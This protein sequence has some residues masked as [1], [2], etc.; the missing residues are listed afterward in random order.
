MFLSFFKIPGCSHW[1]SLIA[2]LV[3]QN[4]IYIS[5]GAV[6]GIR[7]NEAFIIDVKTGPSWRRGDTLDGHKCVLAP[8][9]VSFFLLLFFYWNNHKKV[10]YLCCCNMSWKSEGKKS[11]GR[12][13][14]PRV[15][16]RLLLLLLS[17]WR[18]IFQHNDSPLSWAPF[19]RKTSL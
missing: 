5:S 6:N 14:G 15:E 17:C 18:N 9:K 13:Q 4:W 10:I 16:R 3:H 19:S 2:C 7:T 12:T 11:V 1:R 8:S